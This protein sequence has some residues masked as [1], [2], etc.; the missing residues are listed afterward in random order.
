MEYKITVDYSKTLKRMIDEGKYDYVSS[1]IP[2]HFTVQGEGRKEYTAKLHKISKYMSTKEVIEDMQ[3]EGLRPA[4]VEELLAFGAQYPDEQRDKFF[5]GL[6]SVVVVDGREFVSYLNG[7]PDY[8]YL[9]LSYAD[10]EWYDG[11]WFLGLESESKPSD[12]QS[13]SP[14]DSPSVPCKHFWQLLE[15]TKAFNSIFC[16]HC[17][18]VKKI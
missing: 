1:D 16:A 13:L 14:S 5:V 8:R 9:D 3:K 4:K 10:D 17:T 2:K 12:P 11:P 18:E 6:G 15:V 7:A